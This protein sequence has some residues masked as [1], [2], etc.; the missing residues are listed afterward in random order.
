MALHTPASS[1]QNRS[2]VCG[3][4]AGPC[5]NAYEQEH[6]EPKGTAHAVWYD[7]FFTQ[8]PAAER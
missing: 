1:G 5:P 7:P 3:P 8:S 6:E 4:I 2:P